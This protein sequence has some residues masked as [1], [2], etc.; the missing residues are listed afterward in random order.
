ML[1][2]QCVFSWTPRKCHHICGIKFNRNPDSKVHGANMGPIWGPQDPGG[3]HVGP[4]NFA[5]WEVLDK[6][7]V[8]SLRVPVD[9]E[10]CRRFWNVTC[11]IVE[12]LP[13]IFQSIAI[14]MYAY[15]VNKYSNDHEICLHA[16]KQELM[17]PPRMMCE[18]ECQTVDTFITRVLSRDHFY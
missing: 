10:V 3:P 16:T 7:Q 17:Y 14:K 9:Q 8:Q 4:M 18:M 15:F 1:L 6:C 5:I 12:I 2:S 13:L 11:C